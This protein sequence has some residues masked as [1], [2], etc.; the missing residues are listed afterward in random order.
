MRQK[1]SFAYETVKLNSLSSESSLKKAGRSIVEQ[2]FEEEPLAY[3]LSNHPSQSIKASDPYKQSSLGRGL[4]KGVYNNP[5]V[6]SSAAGL[7]SENH[8]QQIIDKRIAK[9]AQ[10]LK[11]EIT[12][13]K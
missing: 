13:E 11:I 12:A 4:L 5:D 2:V 6:Y 3:D 7:Y 8:E 1:P 9:R 10:E